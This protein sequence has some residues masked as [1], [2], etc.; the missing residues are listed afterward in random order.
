MSYQ[1]I[2]T[3]KADLDILK[4][5]H[6]YDDQQIGLG[7]KFRD[8]MFEKIDMIAKNPLIY[9]I[10]HGTIRSALL[11]GFPHVIYYKISDDKIIV[12]AVL[13]A[14]RNPNLWVERKLYE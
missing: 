11:N 3:R 13:H 12:S 9:R 1:V 5:I 10:R 4:T 8:R 7:N 6:W 2:F 14:K